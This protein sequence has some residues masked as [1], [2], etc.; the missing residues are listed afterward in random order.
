MTNV[1]RWLLMLRVEEIFQLVCMF[2]FACSPACLP[3]VPNVC[4]EDQSEMEK[5]RN[6]YVEASQVVL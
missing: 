6:R 4:D 1:S 3:V 2:I 5:E